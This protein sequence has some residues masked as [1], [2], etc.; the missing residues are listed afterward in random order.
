M[1][2][3][4][5]KDRC[6]ICGGP[7]NLN[8]DPEPG[9]Y[10]GR[11]LNS[12]CRDPK[13]GWNFTSEPRKPL[14]GARQACGF[15]E[16]TSREPQAFGWRK[17]GGRWLCT[18][19]GGEP[20]SVGCSRMMSDATLPSGARVVTRIYDDGES[21]AVYLLR[22]PLPYVV[23]RGATKIEALRTMLRVAASSEGST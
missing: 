4:E 17:V 20:V 10:V 12:T 22:P 15:C 5:V 2:K 9:S 1:H 6:P 8:R 14:R 19:H 18:N 7:G 16:R 13:C 21:F 3:L 11:L 23:G